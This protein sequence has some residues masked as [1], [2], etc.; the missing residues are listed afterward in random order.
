MATSTLSENRSFVK[1]HDGTILA[2]ES[3]AD[4]LAHQ[5]GHSHKIKLFSTYA[6]QTVKFFN[7]SIKAVDISPDEYDNFVKH[8]KAQG[9][10]L[11]PQITSGGFTATRS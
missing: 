10:T 4:I 9:W 3:M 5:A 11:R 1:T 7:G 6:K 2:G 8:L